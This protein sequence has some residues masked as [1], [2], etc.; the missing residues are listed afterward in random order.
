MIDMSPIAYP[1][2]ANSKG[3]LPEAHARRGSHVLVRHLNTLASAALKGCEVVEETKRNYLRSVSPLPLEDPTPAQK[4]AQL[5]RAYADFAEEHHERAQRASAHL[6]AN[7][8]PD[9]CPLQ[10]DRGELGEGSPS[11]TSQ[12]TAQSPP[13]NVMRDWRSQNRYS[14]DTHNRQQMELARELNHARKYRVVNVKPYRSSKVRSPRNSPRAENINS[15]PDLLF[16]TWRDAEEGCKPKLLF[17][18]AIPGKDDLDLSPYQRM[19]KRQHSLAPKVTDPVAGGSPSGRF[20]EKRARSVMVERKRLDFEESTLAR[21]PQPGSK[22]STLDAPLE[23][24][25]RLLSEGPVLNPVRMY[26][27]PNPLADAEPAERTTKDSELSADAAQ[28]YEDAVEDHVGKLIFG[29]KTLSDIEL[30]KFEDRT[31]V[32]GS[33]ISQHIAAKSTGDNA[34]S[35]IATGPK[36]D[37]PATSS[38]SQETTR[39][40]PPL[41]TIPSY[42]TSS[43]RLMALSSRITDGFRARDEVGPKPRHTKHVPQRKLR[44]PSEEDVVLARRISTEIAL[45]ESE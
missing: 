29:R 45:K 23:G 38:T 4:T 20:A 2:K 26:R 27:R 39:D 16:P 24:V 15:R 7:F 40:E 44:G 25:V 18:H 41:P 6:H 13:D 42:S 34:K 10:R 19:R 43:P 21:A 35:S 33:Y 5:Q 12:A 1:V 17:D 9:R 37:A 11:R 36:N 28:V 22:L 31:K 32:G 30:K 8:R 14:M 3:E